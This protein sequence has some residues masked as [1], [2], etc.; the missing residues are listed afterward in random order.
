MGTGSFGSVFWEG[1]R[2][3]VFLPVSDIFIWYIYR[4]KSGSCV[5]WSRIRDE[6]MN[7]FF[8]YRNILLSGNFMDALILHTALFIYQGVWIEWIA[9]ALNPCSRVK[10]PDT[11]PKRTAGGLFPHMEK[12]SSLWRQVRRVP[13]RVF[14]SIRKK[15]AS[16]VHHESGLSAFPHVRENLWTGIR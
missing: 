6:G 1:G 8:S 13:P 12:G 2:K 10:L 9:G 16:V 5:W 7:P 15:Y 3:K 4:Q 11:P 14:P